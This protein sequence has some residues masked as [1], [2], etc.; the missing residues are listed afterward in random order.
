ME[1]DVRVRR[2]AFKSGDGAAGDCTL[3]QRAGNRGARLA[4]EK[5][6]KVPRRL[7]RAT[8]HCKS[9]RARALRRAQTPVGLPGHARELLFRRQ[10]SRNHGGSAVGLASALS[11]EDAPSQTRQA[12]RPSLRRLGA[13][14]SIRSAAAVRRSRRV[15]L[16]QG[17]PTPRLFTRRRGALGSL[18]RAES[19]GCPEEGGRRRFGRTA[20]CPESVVGDAA[21][22]F[23]TV[24]VGLVFD[25]A[26]V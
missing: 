8:R 21:G 18:R 1:G 7:P 19:A 2:G 17:L 23:E 6:P 22:E 11:R 24:C 16:V 3:G 10:P 15:G 4:N 14:S 9:R 25:R 12:P 20:M 13:I 26:V 5:R